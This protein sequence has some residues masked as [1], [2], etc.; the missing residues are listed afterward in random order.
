MNKGDATRAEILRRS[1]A[2]FNTRGYFGTSLADVM[3][4]TGLKKGGIYN[5]FDSKDDLAAE[6]FGYSVDVMRTRWLDAI[7][8]KQTAAEQL[9]AVIDD[10][11]RMRGDPILPGGCPLLNT[12]VDS[13]DAHPALRAR[14]HDAFA[15]WHGL[16]TSI[17]TRG[18]AARE[19][20]DDVDAGRVATTIIM[21]LEGAMALSGVFEE[22]KP[23]EVAREHLHDYI[24]S[25]MRR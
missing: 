20:R 19:F 18:I 16:L 7:S 17:V 14:V 8:G 23:L 22:A 2:V 3:E 24:D 13:D 5:H 4:A 9:T 25:E 6:A 1:A 11:C 21:S 12:A 15:L 10:F